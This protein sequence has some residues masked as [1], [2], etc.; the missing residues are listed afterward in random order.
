MYVFLGWWVVFWF[1]FFSNHLDALLLYG[2]LDYLTI[3]YWICL[4]TDTG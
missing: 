3:V 2:K 1:L 4:R